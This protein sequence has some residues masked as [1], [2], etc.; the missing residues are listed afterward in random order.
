METLKVCHTALNHKRGSCQKLNLHV[1]TVDGPSSN[2]DFT[3]PLYLCLS[4]R[5][6]CMLEHNTS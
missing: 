5:S 4:S 2:T 6:S 1:F 3:A